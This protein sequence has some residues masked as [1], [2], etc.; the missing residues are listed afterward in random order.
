MKKL[1]VTI[2][3]NDENALNLFKNDLTGKKAWLETM[4][5]GKLKIEIGEIEND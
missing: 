2:R 4:S 1:I 5:A 3:S